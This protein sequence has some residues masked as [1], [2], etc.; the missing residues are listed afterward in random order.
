[1]VHNAKYSKF[2]LIKKTLN[3]IIRCRNIMAHTDWQ[4]NINILWDSPEN[5]QTFIIL[6]L[7]HYH[8]ELIYNNF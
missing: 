6:L 7:L 8:H 1:M 2:C 5:R 3:D 4:T